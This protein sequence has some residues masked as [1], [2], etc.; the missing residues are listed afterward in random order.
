VLADKAELEL[1]IPA[2]L[3]DAYVADVS[4]RLTLYKRIAS[5]ASEKQLDDLKVELI[6]RFGL[7]PEPCKNLFAISRLR[8]RCNALGIKRIQVSDNGGFVEFSDKPAIEPMIIITMVQTR[9]ELYKMQGPSKLRFDREL[10]SPQQK[11]SFVQQLI[12][13]F[14]TGSEESGI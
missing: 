1:Q 13:R 11:L 4:M 8:Q 6:D 14:E 7:L 5:A 2:L 9:S 12:H 3:P 10:E